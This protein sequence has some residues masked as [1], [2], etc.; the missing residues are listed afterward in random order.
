MIALVKYEAARAALQAA[1]DVDEVKD[2][3]DKAQAMALYAK[4]ANDTALVE[5]ATEIKVRAERR[6]GTMLAEAKAN[7]SRADSIDNLKSGS[8]TSPK[9][10]DATSGDTLENIGVSKTQSSRW[11]RLAAIPEEQFEKA[12]TEAKGTDGE[13]TTAALLRAAK[14]AKT[15]KVAEPKKA[16]PDETE[17]AKLRKTIDELT[18]E[19]SDLTDTARIAEDKVQALEATEPDEQQKLI[20]ELQK[21]IQRK[22]GEIARLT[23]ERNRLND[24]CNQLIRQVRALQKGRD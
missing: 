20:M 17:I 21:K 15:Q 24:K 16:N 9:S 6:A 11:Q 3:R 1:H 23:A 22:D 4:Q 5:W 12:V 14:P 8:K 13:V 18:E 7:G 2:I 10:H 19:K